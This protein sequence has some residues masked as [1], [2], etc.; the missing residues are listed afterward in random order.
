[1]LH[2]IEILL[3]IY[4]YMVSIFSGRFH[5][6]EPTKESI[7]RRH[8]RRLNAVLIA[9]LILIS[10]VFTLSVGCRDDQARLD[11]TAAID[12]ECQAN[13]G[14]TEASG[15]IIDWDEQERSWSYSIDAAQITFTRNG[16]C[17]DECNFSEKL[18]LAGIADSCPRFVSATYI[19]T[20]AG[21]AHGTVSDTT[22]AG[23][24]VLRIEKWDYPTGV[25]SG[26]LETEVTFTFYITLDAE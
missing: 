21:S 26:T 16:M 15:I 1:M 9:S 5:N 6:D 2:F 11:A 8:T 22:W 19:K 13:L 3:Y 4:G 18:I 20:D 10:M 12:V 14:L 25:V 23:E 7:M 24:G 17:G